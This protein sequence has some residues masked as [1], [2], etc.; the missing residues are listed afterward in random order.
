MA[1]KIDIVIP[2]MG[3]ANS[4]VTKECIKHA[5]LCVPESE[6]KA[7]QEHNPGMEILTHPDSLK[8][9][10]RKRQFI[11]EHFPNSFQIDDD[12]KHIQRIYT[13]SGERAALDADEAYDIVQ[14][15]GNMAKMAGCYLFGFHKDPNPLG[16]HE[17]HPIRLTGI[18]NGC[19]GLLEGSKLYFSEKAVVSEDYWI[20]ALNAYYHRKLWCDERFA[21]CG[22]D[23][24]HNGGGCSNYR[25]L[26]QEEEDTLFLRKTFGE[27]IVLKQDTSIAKRKHEF[28]RS[29]KIPF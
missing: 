3:R 21:I 7:Y 6:K 26:K 13:E 4:L 10:A 12:I 9:L 2:S 22:T 29:L 24:F 8:G 19:V 18:L 17:M 1:V 27:V 14:F 25:T 15:C 23:T 16:Y 28:Q 20:C 5:V 11:Y